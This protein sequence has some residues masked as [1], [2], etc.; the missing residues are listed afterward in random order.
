MSRIIMKVAINK[1]ARLWHDVTQTNDLIGR[2]KILE[3]AQLCT[4][5]HQTLLLTVI[6]CETIT[7]VTPLPRK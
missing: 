4:R 5:S 7:L 2:S 6:R 3:L 1:Y